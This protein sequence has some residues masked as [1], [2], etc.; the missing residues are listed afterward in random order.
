MNLGDWTQ[1][2][3]ITSVVHNNQRNSTTGLS[4][5]QILIGYV[6][7]LHPSEMPPLNNKTTK[8]RIKVLMENHAI[9]TD[10]INQSAKGNGTIPSQY[11]IRDLV[12]LEGKHLKFPH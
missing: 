5:N 4:P 9:P 10:V 8:N 2:L 12:W 1:W 7:D 11:H 3:D 6:P